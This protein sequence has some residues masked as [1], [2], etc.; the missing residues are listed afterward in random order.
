MSEKHI[1]LIEDEEK[2]LDLLLFNLKD[3]FPVTG[4]KDAETFLHDFDPEETAVIITDVR[5]PGMDGL[6]LLDRVQKNSPHIPVII[7]TAF[8]SINQAVSAIK[9]G[10]YDYLTKPVSIEELQEVISRAQQFTS[11]ID[12]LAPLFPA[13]SQFLTNDQDA[14]KQ[15][16]LAARASPMKVPV[17]ILGETGTG[18]ELIAEMIHNASKR[19]GNL[20]KINCAAIPNELLEG[21]LFGYKKGA[22]T[23]ADAGYEGK[24]RL[25]HRGTLFLDEIGDMH[26]ALQAK[27]LRVIETES[28]Y[29]IGEN[30]LCKV[31]IRIIAATN[32]DLKREVDGGKFRSDLYY[33]LAVVPIRIPPLR[34]RPD[35]IPLIGKAFFRQLLENGR[36]NAKTVDEQ[37]YSIFK[38]YM[39][40]GNV[41]ELR[42]VMTNM[43]LLSA[44][45]RITV[46]DIPQELLYSSKQENQWI[47]RIPETYEE[48][49]Q[50]KKRI[51][52]E[53][54][55][56][57]EINFIHQALY[58]NRW[59]I[60]KTA[61]A[62]GIDRRLLQNM[63]KK[64]EINR[65]Y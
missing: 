36:T 43:A 60:T 35:D 22:F 18:K 20:V 23:G 13:D 53:A 42:N 25:S 1:V 16:E 19:E 21:E 4:Y 57:L 26:E 12:P 61:E 32:K 14:I 27:L 64:Y 24:L 34:E 2:L 65:E 15:C 46:D 41:R 8:G 63:I 45:K 7:I 58:N 56:E 55:A 48:L 38:T 39:W 59:N 31:D 17:L 62:V 28:F 6:E 30:R 47:D 40:P 50:K 33:R 9:L 3:D 44:G 11:S 10:A 49:K 37:V 29:P 5:L 54:Y 51:K 52:N